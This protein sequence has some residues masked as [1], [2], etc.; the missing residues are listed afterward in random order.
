MGGLTRYW[1]SHALYGLIGRSF[2]LGTLV[3]NATGCLLMGV[4]SVLILERCLDLNGYLRVFL[5]IGFLG[6]YT[7]FSAFSLETLNLFEQGVWWVA[8]S[9]LLLNVG[10]GITL[11]WLGMFLGRQL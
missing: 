11:T 10:L 2:P 7:T 8:L 5:L 1:I 6:G 4:L 3:V 9:N